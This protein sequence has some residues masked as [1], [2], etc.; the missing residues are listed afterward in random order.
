MRRLCCVRQILF[1]VS[2]VPWSDALLIHWCKWKRHAYSLHPPVV[3][4]AVIY[5]QRHLGR[6]VLLSSRFCEIE[7]WCAIVALQV[8]QLFHCWQLRYQQQQQLHTLREKRAQ[9]SALHCGKEWRRKAQ[10]TRGRKLIVVFK[11]SRVSCVCVCVCVWVRVFV[12]VHVNM[13][14]SQ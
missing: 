12:C 9:R 4:Q 14:I 7:R 1:N 10:N 2:N 8:S 6:C 5:T 3:S 13:Q 11:Y